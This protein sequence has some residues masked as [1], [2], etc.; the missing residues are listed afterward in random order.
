MSATD[1]LSNLGRGLGLG[2]VIAA[3]SSGCTI[4]WGDKTPPEA[5]EEAREAPKV[6]KLYAP[7]A[8]ERAEEHAE[9]ASGEGDADQAALAAA[10]LGTGKAEVSEAAAPPRVRKARRRRRAQMADDGADERLVEDDEPPGALSDGAFQSV[11]TDWSGMKRCLEGTA[12][13]GPSSGA[14]QVRFLIRGDGQVVKSDVVGATNAAAKAIA[15]CVERRARRIRF[16]AFAAASD[17][18]EKTAKFVF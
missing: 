12:R 17:E 3:L 13:L 4:E 8:S 6:R 10:L 1:F 2:L 7:G 9:E 11:I 18:I 16:P 14:L 5:P 15:P